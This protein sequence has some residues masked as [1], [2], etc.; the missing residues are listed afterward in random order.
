MIS[1]ITHKNGKIY[2][3][4]TGTIREASIQSD[5]TGKEEERI[6][7]FTTYETNESITIPISEVKS[8]RVKIAKFDYVK[9]FIIVVGVIGLGA[10]AIAAVFRDNPLVEF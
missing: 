4:V 3:V 8:V 7:F 9:A 5:L 6:I 2:H 1:K 10:L